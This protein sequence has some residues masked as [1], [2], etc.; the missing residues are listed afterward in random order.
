L[1]ANNADV[2]KKFRRAAEGRAAAVRLGEETDWLKK[3]TSFLGVESVG[4]PPSPRLPAADPASIE[5]L[6]A[7]ALVRRSPR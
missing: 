1:R 6:P 4:L 7:A 5:A 3:Q 2:S